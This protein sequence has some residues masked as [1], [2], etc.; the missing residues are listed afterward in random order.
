MMSILMPESVYG[1]GPMSKMTKDSWLS[2]IPV[3]CVCLAGIA[4][5]AFEMTL[6][7]QSCIG[8]L[9]EILSEISNYARR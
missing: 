4:T 5:G 3:L 1:T 6:L 8:G 7:L 9:T 2:Y